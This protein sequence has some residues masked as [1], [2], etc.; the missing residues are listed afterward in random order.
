LWQNILGDLNECLK[1]GANSRRNV[2]QH[3]EIQHNDIQRNEV[4][5]N[6]IQHNEVQHNDI[7]YNDIKTMTIT[8]TL[9][10]MTHYAKCTLCLESQFSLLC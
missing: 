4:Q 3:N 9:G 1:L 5:L 7:Q 8:T 10:I 6:D 2:I